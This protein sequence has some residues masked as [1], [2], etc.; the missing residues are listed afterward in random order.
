MTPPDS[1]DATRE[2]E[3]ILPAYSVEYIQAN[4]AEVRDLCERYALQARKVCAENLQKARRGMDFWVGS[5]DSAP[6]V[7]KMQKENEA[8]AKYGLSKRWS[9]LDI[10]EACQSPRGVVITV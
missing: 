8:L 7:T 4:E 6:R 2:E 5:W 3:I 9:E 10:D 1:P